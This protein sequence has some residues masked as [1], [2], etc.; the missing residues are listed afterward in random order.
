VDIDEY[1]IEALEDVLNMAYEY[2]EEY[3]LTSSRPCLGDVSTLLDRLKEYCHSN[4]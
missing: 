4:E 1:E 2:C 3:N